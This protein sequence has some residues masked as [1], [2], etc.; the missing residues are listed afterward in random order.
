MFLFAQEMVK[1][2]K[3]TEKNKINL[4]GFCFNA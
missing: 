3:I 2:P 1:D 4:E